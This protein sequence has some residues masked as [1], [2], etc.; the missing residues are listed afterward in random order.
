MVKEYTEIKIIKNNKKNSSSTFSAF[1]DQV[2]ITVICLVKDIQMKC[3][4][5]NLIL[6]AL[7]RYVQRHNYLSWLTLND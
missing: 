7:N 4:R 2:L 3:L 6:L 5:I 1:V